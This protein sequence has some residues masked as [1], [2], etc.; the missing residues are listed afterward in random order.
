MVEILYLSDG[1]TGVAV[2][3]HRTERVLVVSVYFDGLVEMETHLEKLDKIKSFAGKHCNELF[4]SGDVNAHGCLWGERSTER[5]LAL[6]GYVVGS[7]LC[8][9]NDG[10]PT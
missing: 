9:L 8:V 5:G 6:E 2:W 3:L 10:S 4:I 1:D 7:G